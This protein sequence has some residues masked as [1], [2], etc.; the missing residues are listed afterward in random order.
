MSHRLRL[1][2]AIYPVADLAAAR[3]WYA[4]W[5]GIQPYFDQ[6]FYVGFDIEGFELGLHPDSPAHHAHR[7][8][9]V[10]YWKT[11]DLD[12]EWKTLLA[13]GGT[14]LSA[15]RDVGGG[16]RVAE[17]RDPFGNTIGLIEERPA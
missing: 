7:G 6:P 2:S 17:V 9:G 16:V 11:P 14:E 5:L 12:A 15:P 4:E 8:G 3:K 1:R 10:P 13:H